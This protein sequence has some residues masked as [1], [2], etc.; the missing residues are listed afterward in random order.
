MLFTI[1]AQQRIED[2]QLVYQAVSHFD[3]Y[4]RKKRYH[5]LKQAFMTGCVALFIASKN[6]DPYPFSLN[7]ISKHF[8]Q[9]HYLKEELLARELELLEAGARAGCGGPFWR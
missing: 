8:L 2:K 1:C 3:R 4:Y 9:N 6:S 7:D 5:N